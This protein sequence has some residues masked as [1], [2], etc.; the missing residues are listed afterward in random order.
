MRFHILAIAAILCAPAASAFAVEQVKPRPSPPQS[1]MLTAEMMEANVVEFEV[2]AVSV[3]SRLPNYCA[4]SAMVLKVWAGKAF[5]EGLPL[6]LNVP[7]AEYGLVPAAA[8]HDGFT[9]V[10]ARSLQ[11]SRR[12]I[13]R[14]SDTGEILW[15]A[16]MMRPYGPWGTVFGYRVL[17]ARMIPAELR[18]S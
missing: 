16:G 6:A 10:N 2:M 8:A 13:A 4:V 12:G 11:Q 7:C 9:P 14:L 17:D 5:R 15:N 18:P 1:I 3:P